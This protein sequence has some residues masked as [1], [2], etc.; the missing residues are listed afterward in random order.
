MQFYLIFKKNFLTPYVLF[1]RDIDV[2]E[3]VLK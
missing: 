2:V 3:Y 1:D